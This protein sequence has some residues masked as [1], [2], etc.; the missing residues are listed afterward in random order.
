MVPEPLRGLSGLEV[1]RNG[2]VVPSAEWGVAIPLDP[3]VV[4][5]H[6]VATGKT[7]WE[8]TVDVQREGVTESM[9]VPVL[10][11]VPKEPKEPKEPAPPEKVLPPPVVHP[12]AVTSPGPFWSVPRVIGAVAGAVGA[13]LVIGG[14]YSGL[15]SKSK[16]DAS[17]ENGHCVDG[18]QCDAIGFALQKDALAA[19]NVATGLFVPGAI[20]LVGGVAIVI[21]GPRGPASSSVQVAMSPRGISFHGSW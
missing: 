17:H 9:T 10:S 19:G 20:L 7:G 21:A 18:N 6:V 8:Q 15:E 12:K 2:V 14:S 3:G 5:V 4:R 16:R 13:G 1:T 11:D